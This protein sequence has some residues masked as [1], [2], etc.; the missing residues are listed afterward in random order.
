MLEISLGGMVTILGLL[1]I[2]AGAIRFAVALRD[3]SFEDDE[4]K[5]KIFTLIGFLVFNI[6]L[7][8]YGLTPT[9]EKYEIQSRVEN[10]SDVENIYCNDE[11][12]G[13]LKLI[14]LD[15]NE[16]TICPTLKENEKPYI[17]R[18]INGFGKC[19]YIKIYIPENAGDDLK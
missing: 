11:E 16:I 18:S 7:V 5:I 8:I 14:K 15:I 10:I 6:G 13:E 1:I 19:K 3:F 9:V 2:V 12:T 17:E 4:F